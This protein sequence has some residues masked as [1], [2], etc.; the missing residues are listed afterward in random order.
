MQLSGYSVLIV[1]GIHQESVVIGIRDSHQT[2]LLVIVIF[3]Y[4][5]EGIVRI[6]GLRYFDEAIAIVVVESPCA[7][8]IVLDL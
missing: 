3:S 8:G 5:I 1:V 4:H 6:E 7:L 2:I